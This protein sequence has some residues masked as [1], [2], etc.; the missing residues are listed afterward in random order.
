[1]SLSFVKTGLS[2]DDPTYPMVEIAEQSAARAAELVAQLLAHAGKGKFV[3]TRFDLSAL[4]SE[5]LPLIAAS[6]P[7]NVELDLLLAP[8]LSWIEADASQ[9]RQI[10][11]NLIINGAEAIGAERGTVRV[12][13]GVSNSEDDIFME[14]TDSGSGMNEIT[15]AKM[16]EPFFTTK[17][18]G[19]GLGLAAVSGIVRAHNGKIQVDSSPGQGTTFTVSFPAV[20]ATVLTPPDLPSLIVTRD[21]GTVLIVDDEPAL[22]KIAAAILEKSGYSVLVAKDGREAVEVFQQNAPQVAAVLLDITMPVMAG[23]EAFRLIRDIQPRVP[24]IMSSGYSETF[25]LEKLGSDV[26]AAFIQKP[27]TAA[28]LI[29][30][31]QKACAISRAD[32]AR[33]AAQS[34]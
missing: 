1:M 12:R 22:R 11:M 28:K 14:V 34:D 31:I 30:S 8:G 10:V 27:Y 9:I 3:I 33:P 15:K 13:S 19:R 6:I 17:L 5:M 7:K 29:E 32:Y 21:I 24:I 16:F 4:I 20:Q 25:A 26:A 2:L 18:M 23:H